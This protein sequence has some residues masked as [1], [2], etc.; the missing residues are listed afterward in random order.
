M[1]D[2][3]AAIVGFYQDRLAGTR[4][5]QNLKKHK[6]FSIWADTRLEN[7]MAIDSS[8]TSTD[9]LP[10]LIKSFPNTYL[11]SIGK[12]V[13]G[14]ATMIMMKEAAK[15]GYEYVIVLG[16]DEY[17]EGEWETTKQALDYLQL[18][19]PTRIKL[20]II[21]HNPLKNNNASWQGR[22]VYM[23]Q[24]VE[25]GQI[26]WLYYS[27]YKGRR[28]IIGDIHQDPIVF[29]AEIHHDDSIRP[30]WRNN[31]MDVWQRHRTELETQELGKLVLTGQIEKFNKERTIENN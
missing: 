12:T 24:Y 11:M 22:I 23:P 8:N 18:K 14:Q 3:I 25:I 17:I 1:T 28:K 29:G 2:N 27:T 26:H 20:P 13:P 9:G 5:L 16:C 7:F 15:L 4:L 19:E 21:E 30:E 10:Q 6:I 31:L